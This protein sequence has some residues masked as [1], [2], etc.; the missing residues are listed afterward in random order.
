MRQENW[1][2][3][4]LWMIKVEQDVGQRGY[5]KAKSNLD[6]GEYVDASHRLISIFETIMGSSE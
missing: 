6:F 2:M 1:N 5:S 3:V 4:Y